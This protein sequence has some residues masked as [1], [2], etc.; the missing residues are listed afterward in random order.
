MPMLFVGCVSDV[1]FDQIDDIEINTPHNITLAYFDLD[2]TSFSDDLGNQSLFISDTTEFPFFNNSGN[3][4]YLVR[5][6]FNFEAANSFDRAITFEFKF[7]DQ[8]ENETY[9][10]TPLV[11]AANN[12]NF[13][14][15][16]TILENDIQALVQ[17][18]YAVVSILLE[19]SSNPLDQSMNF[20]FKS[21]VTLHYQYTVD[22][23]E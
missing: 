9:E 14:Q 17:T 3:E 1:D 13:S 22:D 5:A 12:L 2:A 21:G 6:D 7:L 23:E 20:E 19:A 4:N 15:Q 18:Q 10:F 11:V 8:F 16:E